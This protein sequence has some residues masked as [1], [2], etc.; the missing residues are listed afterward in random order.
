VTGPRPNA[1]TVLDQ[2]AQAAQAV[3]QPTQPI[4]IPAEAVADIRPGSVGQSL[5][6]QPPSTS[7]VRAAHRDRRLRRT[8]RSCCR[9]A[10]RGPL[11]G[12]AAP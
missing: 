7:H 12:T 4:R 3:T 9:A 6:P 1:R 10:A 8:P 11:S 5:S 2:S